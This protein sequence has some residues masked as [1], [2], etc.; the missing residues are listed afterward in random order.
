M[1]DRQLQT[2]VRNVFNEDP[3][4]IRRV[5]GGD[6]N[7]AV[8]VEVDAGRYFLKVNDNAP[9]GFF[10]AEARGL[11]RLRA[12][13]GLRVPAVIA[14]A[15]ADGDLPAY[16]VLEWLDEAPASPTFATRF[17]EVLAALH[18][19]S[20]AQFGLD[21]DNFI[22]KLP[23]RNTPM[24]RWADFYRDQRIAPQA[25]LA[26]QRGMSA[27]RLALLD[28]L[29]ARLSNLLP[30]KSTPALLHG[31]L[32]R[33]NYMIL[34]GDVPAVIDPAVYYGDREIELA[35]TELFGGFPAQFYTAYRAIYPLEPGYAE[36]RSL[37]QL[38]PLLVHYNLFGE[39][40]GAHVES[41]C[42]RYL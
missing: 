18:Q 38:Y 30:N 40:Y 37:Y 41:V 35:F 39:P 16:L 36:R 9:R 7:E 24:D 31:D 34:A 4:S 19:I 23:Q 12:G 3:Q 8:C 21:S 29:M 27:S 22:G 17:G 2:I 32:W 6:I 26:R 1:H 25:V 20:Q 13:H 42:R 15:E 10:A 28:R 14:E 33:G 11:E 5:H